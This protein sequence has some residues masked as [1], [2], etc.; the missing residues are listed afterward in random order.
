MVAIHTQT[1]GRACWEKCAKLKTNWLP[2]YRAIQPSRPK[3]L[4]FHWCGRGRRLPTQPSVNCNGQRPLPD[5]HLLP[6]LL[7]LVHVQCV[8]RAHLPGGLLTLSWQGPRT[9]INT[10]LPDIFPRLS[11]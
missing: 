8:G 6:P 11:V 7:S 5:Q 4:S 10:S 3:S 1:W 2:S 9:I